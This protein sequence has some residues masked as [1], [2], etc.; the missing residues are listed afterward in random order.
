MKAE[1]A[2]RG[3]FGPVWEWDQGSGK[4][5]PA[6]PNGILNESVPKSTDFRSNSD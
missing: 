6:M 3:S 5:R 2:N 4:A 1:C